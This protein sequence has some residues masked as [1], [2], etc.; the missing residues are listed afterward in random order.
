VRTTMDDEQGSWS[1]D[2]LA[3][4]GVGVSARDSQAREAT[5]RQR[6]SGGTVALEEGGA[7][8]PSHSNGGRKRARK[9]RKEVFRRRPGVIASTV[10]GVLLIAGAA[11]AVALWRSQPP[12]S[13]G[14]GQ[15]SSSQTNGPLS[16]TTGS[17]RVVSVTELTQDG[18][19]P[20]DNLSELPNL[21]DGNLTTFWES[22]LYNGPNFGG[23]G[24]FGLVMKLGSERTL[25]D[26]VVSTSM[27]GWSAETFASNTDAS[28]VSGWGTPTAKQSPIYG[29]T[30]FSLADRKAS[31]VLLWMTDPGPTRQAQIE[32]LTVR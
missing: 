1:E 28:A 21:T 17:I 24:G 32:E 10:V 8:A 4:G 13:Q 19:L 27:Q 6:P 22:A 15:T 9:R 29:S 31:W 20:N 11:V 3:A 14:S 26:L 23:Y 16:N 2:G 5:V 30:T 12:T 25:H 7:G 18:N